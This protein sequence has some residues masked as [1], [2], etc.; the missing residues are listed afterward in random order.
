M[1]RLHWF[2][3]VDQGAQD[4]MG[5]R[6]V[7]LVILL[8][9]ANQVLMSSMAPV[10]AFARI[11][12]VRSAS[13]KTIIAPALS[14]DGKTTRLVEQPTISDVPANPNSGDAVADAKVVLLPTDSPFYAPEGIS[15]RDAVNA[16]KKW[17]EYEKSI[18]LTGTALER[19]D[20]LTDILPCNYCCG[21]PTQVTHNRQ[22][23]C[24]HAKAARGF[25]KY[26]LSTYG[27]TYS[28]EQLLG[29]AFR[30]QAIWYPK[31][32]VEDYLLA[33]G[34]ESIIGHATHG[35][36]GKDGMHGVGK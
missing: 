14:S 23:G 22:C 34:K 11:L 32:A 29:E 10:S 3:S 9:A 24:A 21:S 33:T 26:M 2:T 6:V 20:T 28:N 30:W 17:G 15:F 16:E 35:G 12:N 8:F 19:Y 1:K 18:S 7:W 36:A 27:D 13:A 25:F 4:R 31:G 5:R